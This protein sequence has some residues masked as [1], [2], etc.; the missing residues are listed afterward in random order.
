MLRVRIICGGILLA[1]ALGL[2]FAPICTVISWCIL[3]WFLQYHEIM[4]L[5]NSFLE[6][7]ISV[8]LAPIQV[9]TI[10]LIWF[11]NGGGPIM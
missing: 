5:N 1:L 10:I 2:W 11:L 8:L 7:C 6:S 4:S 3:S 9:L